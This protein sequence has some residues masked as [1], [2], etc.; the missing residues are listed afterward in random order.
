[1]TDIEQPKDK[2]GIEKLRAAYREGR[3]R[4]GAPVTEE[5]VLEIFPDNMIEGLE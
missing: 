1:M 3:R 4:M 2:E 5:E